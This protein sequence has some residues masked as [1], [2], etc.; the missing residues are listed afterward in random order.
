MI[1]T[2]VGAAHGFIVSA[3]IGIATASLSGG[4]GG[5]DDDDDDDDDNITPQ[6]LQTSIPNNNLKLSCQSLHRLS[7]AKLN[8]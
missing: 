3:F 7:S 5:G 8:V 4:G 2:V 1:A 6:P